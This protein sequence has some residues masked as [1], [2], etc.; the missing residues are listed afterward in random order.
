MKNSCIVK[1]SRPFRATGNRTLEDLYRENN[2][3]D[4]DKAS[5]LLQVNDAL[6]KL[7][8]WNFLE[9]TEAIQAAFSQF[10]N[11][12]YNDPELL[13]KIKNKLRKAIH[14]D[15]NKGNAQQACE[16]YK[17]IDGLFD[18]REYYETKFIQ[19]VDKKVKQ[20]KA[21]KARAES[22]EIIINE[23]KN[24]CSPQ[25]YQACL[26]HHFGFKIMEAI[27]EQII[28]GMLN[29]MSDNTMKEDI[30]LQL[31]NNELTHLELLT[32]IARTD[33]DY[34]TIEEMRA[35]ISGNNKV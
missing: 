17:T 8:N 22:N 4:Q 12:H 28:R 2:A 18:H 3:S 15:K 13:E 23:L 30:A 1:T 9:T 29:I 24:L 33:K 11:I 16:I 21:R 10:I 14:P 5:S 31:K 32:K 34:E 35:E 20:N 19:H 7:Q 27:M 6:L 26:A 25:T